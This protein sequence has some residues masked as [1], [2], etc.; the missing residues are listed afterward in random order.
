MINFFYLHLD[1]FFINITNW[2]TRDKYRI[3]GYIALAILVVV[4]S[5]L[6]YLNLVLT[7]KLILFLIFMLAFIIFRVSWKIIIYV[8]LIFFV[9]AFILTITGF[10]TTSMFLGDF[11]YGFLV[12][13]AVIYFIKI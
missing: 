10:T 1:K 6:P 8:C 2:V 11:I 13:V 5:F 9:L 3:V 4:A 12:F 7:N